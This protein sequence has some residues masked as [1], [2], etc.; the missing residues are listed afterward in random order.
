[1][2]TGVE[3]AGFVLAVLPLV[4]NQLDQYVQGIET[5]KSFRTRRYRRELKSW[6]VN[7][8]SQKTIFENNILILL[9]DIDTSDESVAEFLK[10]CR[11]SGHWDSSQ[12]EKELQKYLGA[13]Y[14]I[15]MA[16][17]HELQFLVQQV[18]E[19]FGLNPESVDKV[20]CG[21]FLPATEH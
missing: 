12:I 5:I 10:S 8:G 17:M 15:Y 7:L 21:P 3:A 11:R 13:S 20:S 14:D 18:N 19:K 6:H 1:M 4:V 16:N 9:S 2:A